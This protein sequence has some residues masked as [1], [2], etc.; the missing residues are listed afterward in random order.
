MNKNDR[1]DN[2]QQIPYRGNKK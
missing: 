1:R 2:K